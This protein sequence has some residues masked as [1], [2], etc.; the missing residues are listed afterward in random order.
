MVKRT[1][2]GGSLTNETLLERIPRKGK[3]SEAP[4]A[5]LKEIS[6]QLKLFK[7]GQAELAMLEKDIERELERL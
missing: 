6:R 1:T 3:F 7:F 4:T 2:G 5:R